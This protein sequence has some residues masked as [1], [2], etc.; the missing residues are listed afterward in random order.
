MSPVNLLVLSNP[1]AGYLRLLKRLPPSVVIAVNNNSDYLAREAPG[2]DVILN[3]FSPGDLL[4]AVFPLTKKVRWIHTL[5]AGVENLLWPE[6]TESPVLLTNGRGVYRRS[7]AEWAVG[8]ALFFAKDFRR[9]VRQQDAGAWEQ[10][11]VEELHGRTLGIVGYGEI[12]RAVAEKARAFGMEV[13]AM[14]RH[15][16]ISAGEEL[17]TMF[18]PSHL[19]DMLKVSDYVLIS[20]PGTPATKRMIGD[21]E[22]AVMKPSAVIINIGRGSVIDEAALV[23]ALREKRIRGAALD[24]F[25]REPLI[26]GHPLYGISNVLLSPHCADHAEG[27]RDLAME[28]F[29]RNFEHFIKGEPLDNVVDKR[30]GY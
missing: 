6:L 17:A 28:V 16:E 8:A 5:S 13:I 23:R 9:L 30:A 27:T 22:F 11:D 2:A 3:A 12:G 24:V 29:L 21:S 4:R 15:P 7:L 1:A 14:R 10:F 20:A 26:D 18:G 25:E 19:H